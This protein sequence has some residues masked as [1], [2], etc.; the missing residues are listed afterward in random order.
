LNGGETAEAPD[1]LLA[2]TLSAL[3]DP[4]T[5]LIDRRIGDGLEPVDVVLIHPE[6]G[7]ALVDNAPRDPAASAAALRA[8]LESE[9]FSEFFP[10]E[11]PVVALSVASEEIA[12]IGDRLAAAF[13]AAP[14][15]TIED[16]DW[17]DAVIELLLVPEDLSM[18]PMGGAARSN[19]APTPSPLFEPPA[20][21]VPEPRH[22]PQGETGI[23]PLHLMADWRPSDEEARAGT[24]RWAIAAAA[25]FILLAAAGMA[26]EL[27]D[28]G[29]G[30]A[31]LTAARQ[32]EVPVTAARDTQMAP[33]KSAPAPA[34]SPPPVPPRPLLVFAAKPMVPPPRPLPRVAFVEA[35]K[36]VA[37]EKPPTP[38]AVQTADR[39]PPQA[40]PIAA[41]EPPPTPVQTPKPAPP[42]H[43]A[44]AEPPPPAKRPPPQ[45]VA[46]APARAP[47][48]A[49]ERADHPP[50]DAADLPPLD[51]AL[52]TPPPAP[53]TQAAEAP[54]PRETVASREPPTRLP[55]ISN[56]AVPAPKIGPPIPLAHPPWQPQSGSTLPRTRAVAEAP[57]NAANGKSQECRPYT[58]DTSL[59]GRSLPVRGMACRGADGQWRLVSE[60]PAR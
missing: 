8:R 18:A 34:P 47:E 4:W 17:A 26:W 59:T 27:G 53:P 11:L 36:F 19:P 38:A 58:A 5:L 42:P 14:R 13:D 55:E 32:V 52:P 40:T 50:I 9:R 57:P 39:A 30:E 10:G 21:P 23:P 12:E 6:I 37:K 54:P 48:H 45:H 41:A 56:D 29:S 46:A 2:A 1:N 28:D 31:T 7:I 51:D 24:R 25:I 60:L 22:A 49:I 3:P 15:L 43:I 16:R 20:A 33:A 44:K 35:P